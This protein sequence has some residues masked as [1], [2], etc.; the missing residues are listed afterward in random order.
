MKAVE[1]AE[2][3]ADWVEAVAWQICKHSEVGTLRSVVVA[4]DEDGVRFK[5]NDQEWTPS[6][7]ELVEDDGITAA[8]ERQWN[9]WR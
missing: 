9:D 1:L 6:H 2:E 5:I 4:I 3:A 7:G 8:Q